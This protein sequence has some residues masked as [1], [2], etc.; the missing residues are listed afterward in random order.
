MVYTEVRNTDG[1]KRF[2]RVYTY[3][4]K[5]NV[6]HRT[7]YLG[8]DLSQKQREQREREAD[9]HLIH[10]LQALLSTRELRMLSAIR[11][12]HLG[13]SPATLDNRYEAFASEFT[14]DSTGIEGNTLTLPET[15]AVLFE[16][17]TPAKSLRE[18]YEVINH[19]RALDYLLAHHG[20]VTKALLCRLQRLVTEN[21]LRQ[22]LRA[23]AGRYRTVPVFIRGASVTPPPARLVA[24]E[25]RSLLAWYG[26]NKSKLHPVVVAAYFHAAFEAIHPF[27]DGNGR[28]GRLALNLMLHR[29]GYPMVS[30]PRTQ[31]VRYFNALAHAQIDGDF[32]PLITLLIERLKNSDKSV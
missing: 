13:K 29:K 15:A 19:K 12:K 10:P 8:T 17:A 2:Y 32:R 21:T 1:K 11:K 9:V 23:Q 22:E 3:R 14:Y 5:G 20:D 18:V 6:V 30:I 27:V 26:K 16:G 25:M 31:K 7:I 28:A 24:K 4:K